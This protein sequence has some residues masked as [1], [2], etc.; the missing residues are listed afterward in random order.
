MFQRWG[1]INFIAHLIDH[2]N[3]SFIGSWWME[4]ARELVSRQSASQPAESAKYFAVGSLTQIK[5]V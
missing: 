1:P 2:K 3:Y 5:A 4:T